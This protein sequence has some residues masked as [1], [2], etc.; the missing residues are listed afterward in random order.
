M[1]AGAQNQMP[2]VFVSYSHKDKEWLD[3]VL[4]Y[5]KAA[6]RQGNFEIWSD[7]EIRKGDRWYKDIQDTLEQTRFAVCLVTGIE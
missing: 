4:P 5:L 2:T 6:Q 3:L 7:L 1:A